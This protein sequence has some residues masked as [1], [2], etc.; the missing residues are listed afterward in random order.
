MSPGGKRRWGKVNIPFLYIFL[1][2]YVLSNC[3][4]VIWDRKKLISTSYALS[5]ISWEL[6]GRETRFMRAR[7]SETKRRCTHFYDAKQST[8]FKLQLKVT[9]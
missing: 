6:E 1:F 2:V 7:M 9:F 3:S 5:L 8:L 4:Q